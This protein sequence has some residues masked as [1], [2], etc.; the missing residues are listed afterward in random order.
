MS[1]RAG[2][3]GWG[4]GHRDRGHC[5]VEDWVRI[6][7]LPLATAEPQLLHQESGAMVSTS[8]GLRDEKKYHKWKMRGLF[9]GCVIKG[10]T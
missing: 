4:G 9:L 5:G 3:W 6:L 8:E 10:W 7:L 1:L 2:R